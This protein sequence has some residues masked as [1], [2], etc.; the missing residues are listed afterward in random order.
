ME[1]D[2]AYY[3][4]LDAEESERVQ[5]MIQEIEHILTSDGCLKGVQI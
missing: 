3:I 5:D 2:G 4:I 1:I